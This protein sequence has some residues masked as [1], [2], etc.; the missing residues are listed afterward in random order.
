MEKSEIS[1]QCVSKPPLQISFN[2][3]FSQKSIMV[4]IHKKASKWSFMPRLLIV[5][6]LCILEHYIFLSPT[7][8]L[9]YRRSPFWKVELRCY[10]PAL[11]HIS[12]LSSPSFFLGLLPSRPFHIFV[13]PSL[14]SLDS[15]CIWSI[16]L[17]ISLYSLSHRLFWNQWIYSRVHRLPL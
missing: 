9:L 13:P 8:L 16:P 4:V 7:I 1:T 11:Y 15:L 12:P 14:W 3:F 10:I 17:S 6:F 2:E 5:S